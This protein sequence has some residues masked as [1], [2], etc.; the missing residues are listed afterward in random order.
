M[1]DG[2][3]ND[4]RQTVVNAVLSI[5]EIGDDYE[6]MKAGLKGAAMRA[7][8]GAIGLDI[9]PDNLTAESLGRA[10][11]KLVAGS[12]DLPVMNVF[13]AAEVRAG[14]IKYGC[15][16]IND[17][18]GVSSGSSPEGVGRAV[19]AL[20]QAEV[21]DGLRG[22]N[23]AIVDAVRISAR[24]LSKYGAVDDVKPLKPGDKAQ[25]NRDRQARYRLTHRK[26]FV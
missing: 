14:L 10:V 9:D 18:L 13:D 1:A 4:D 17:R 23:Q 24:R 19:A 21:I 3:F 5:I 7:A 2:D 25:S 6:R 15:A 8:F 11:G 22:G 26:V 12:S 16:Q 20:V